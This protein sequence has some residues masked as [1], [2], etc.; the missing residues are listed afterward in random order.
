MSQT[1]ALRKKRGTSGAVSRACYVVLRT[2][3]E[4]TDGKL[5][6]FADSEDT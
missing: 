1:T 2:V 3:N 6:L 4:L 5:I